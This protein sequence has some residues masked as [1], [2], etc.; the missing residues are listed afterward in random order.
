MSDV[1]AAEEAGLHRMESTEDDAAFR[2]GSCQT[3]CGVEEESLQAALLM[4]VVSGAAAGAVVDSSAEAASEAG[5][6]LARSGEVEL[7]CALEMASM[8]SS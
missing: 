5:I 7:C 6:V 1:I 3:A 4:F 2:A 8:L